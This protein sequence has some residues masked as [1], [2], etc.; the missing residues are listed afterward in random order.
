MPAVNSSDS[1]ES[2]YILLQEQKNKYRGIIDR[3]SHDNKRKTNTIELLKNQL[4]L[5]KKALSLAGLELDMKEL[6]SLVSNRIKEKA[7]YEKYEKGVIA[8]KGPELVPRPP[9]ESDPEKTYF[10]LST[11][12]TLVKK[13]ATLEE[14]QSQITK[15]YIERIL[16]INREST[17]SNHENITKKENVIKSNKHTKEVPEVSLNYQESIQ[18]VPPVAEPPKSIFNQK[19][20][21]PP[22]HIEDQATMQEM[23]Q[24]KFDALDIESNFE[25]FETASLNRWKNHDDPPMATE[26]QSILEL[27]SGHKS[28]IA[29]R[30]ERKQ[31]LKPKGL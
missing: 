3:L 2:I 15:S 20:P 19:E 27:L 21:L 10:S 24:R 23:D 18:E 8:E 14:T 9:V 5:I 16:A 30:A 29:D 12:K 25:A 31:R 7:D 13:A 11:E 6:Q 1:Q 22:I 28:I 26:N 17:I 4:D